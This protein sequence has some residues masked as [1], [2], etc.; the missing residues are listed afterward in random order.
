MKPIMNAEH[1]ALLRSVSECYP[2]VLRLVL[3]AM[4]LPPMSDGGPRR[5]NLARC[6]PLAL[7]VVLATRYSGEDAEELAQMMFQGAFSPAADTH[8]GVLEVWERVQAH[9]AAHD[10]GGTV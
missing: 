10:Q 6:M 9:L 2:D 7:G 1:T 5:P 8:P 4:L 3:T